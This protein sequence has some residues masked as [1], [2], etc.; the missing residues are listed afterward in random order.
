MFDKKS[1]SIFFGINILLRRLTQE[2]YSLT[3]M[4]IA[5]KNDKFKFFIILFCEIVVEVMKK[6][7]S[8]Q[9]E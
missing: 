4:K 2:K 5:D 9:D 6:V 1:K 3:I 7:Y 8:F